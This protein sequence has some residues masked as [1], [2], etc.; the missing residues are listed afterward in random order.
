MR[1]Q[2]RAVTAGVFTGATTN[3]PALAAVLQHAAESQ[4]HDA[5]ALTDP[6]VG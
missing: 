4:A 2:S 5:R 6:V 1:G 3:T